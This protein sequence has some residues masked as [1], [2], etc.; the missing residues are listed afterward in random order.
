MYSRILQATATSALTVVLPSCS[1][2][3]AAAPGFSRDETR[4]L[5]STYYWQQGQKPFTYTSEQL[6]ALLRRSADPAFDGEMA[7]SATIALVCALAAVGDDIFS[8]ALT[9][10]SEAVKRAVARDVSYLW[11]HFKLHYPKTERV[12]RPYI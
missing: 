2:L 3:P 9:R 12:L 11:T 10:H 4:V 1:S 8:Q 5:V 6:D 7:E